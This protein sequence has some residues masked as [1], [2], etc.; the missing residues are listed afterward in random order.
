MIE[1]YVDGACKNNP[2]VGGY[3]IY[4]KFPNGKEE[5][6]AKRFENTT[7]NK[8][9]LMAV[10][11]AMKLIH[12]SITETIKIYTDSQYVY[13]GITIW[14]KMWKKKNWVNSKNETIANLE[15]WKEFDIVCKNCSNFDHIHFQ[16]VK[17]HAGNPG[18]EM[19]D[20]LANQA[21]FSSTD[22]NNI[23]WQNSKSIL[24]SVMN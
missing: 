4:I 5:K 10:I 1:I 11:E 17:A 23:M 18:N 22:E 16:W 19:A 15:L 3:G 14:L 6:Y 8:M 20:F 2:G 12:P 9:E 7:N 21:I 13:K 24:S